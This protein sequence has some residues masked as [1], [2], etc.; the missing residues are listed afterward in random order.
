MQFKIFL[1]KLSSPLIIF[2]LNNYFTLA[3]TSS[4]G[5]NY[6]VFGDVKITLNHEF[7]TLIGDY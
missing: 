2:F 7:L 4:I 5:F 3:H 6:G 1:C